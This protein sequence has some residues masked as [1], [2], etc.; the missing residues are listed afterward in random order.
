MRSFKFIL[1]QDIACFA[2]RV[3]FDNLL[4]YSLVHSNLALIYIFNCLFQHLVNGQKVDDGNITC[5][6]R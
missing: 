3:L 6:A 1:K 5:H 2:W 4:M